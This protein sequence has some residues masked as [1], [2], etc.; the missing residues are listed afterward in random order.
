MIPA[1][2]SRGGQEPFA[3]A[4]ALGSRRLAAR[5]G[6]RPLLFP[7]RFVAEGL[8][9]PHPLLPADPFERAR[10][11]LVIDRFGSKAVPKFY[12]MLLKQV[13]VLLCTAPAAA[14]LLLFTACHTA[15]RRRSCTKWTMP[16]HANIF[17]IL[18]SRQRRRA[19]S[20]RSS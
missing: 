7:L 11:R 19:R 12:K 2:C 16:F 20:M 8:P 10:A 3:S 4:T 1:W 17:R 9:G 13:R 6:W 18:P 5:S 14:L 15:C